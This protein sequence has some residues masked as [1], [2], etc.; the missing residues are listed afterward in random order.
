MRHRIPRGK[1]VKVFP[2]DK[3]ELLPDSESTSR[4]FPINFL[5]LGEPRVVPWSIAGM[6]K[7]VNAIETREIVRGKPPIKLIQ[8]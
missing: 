7:S 3:P 6:S 8:K 4:P 1:D 2:V 5:V